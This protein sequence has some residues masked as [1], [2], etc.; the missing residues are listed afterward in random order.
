MKTHTILVQKQKN[1]WFV[2]VGPHC[3]GKYSTRGRELAIKTAKSLCYLFSSM[4]I[5]TELEIEG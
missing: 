3:F 2:F 4:N 1:H 5:K